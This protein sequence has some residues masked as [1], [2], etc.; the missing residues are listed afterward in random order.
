MSS[1]PATLSLARR[2]ST[3][4]SDRNGNFQKPK[5]MAARA[6]TFA[7]LPET[8]LKCPAPP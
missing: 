7:F 3:T 6:P 5:K 4:N 1:S 8:L 2:N